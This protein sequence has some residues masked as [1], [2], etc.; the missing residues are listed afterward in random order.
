MA[1]IADLAAKITLTQ[2]REVLWRCYNIEQATGVRYTPMFIGAPGNGK[3]SIVEQ[4]TLELDAKLRE[5]GGAGAICVPF[6]LAQC[7][8]TDLKGVPVY[9]ELNGKKVC[10]YAPPRNIPLKG[11]PD[12]ADG[13]F[14]VLFLDELPQALPTIQNLASNIVDGKIGDYEIDFSRCFIVVA[15]NRKEDKAAV[16]DTPNNV[17]NRVDTLIVNITFSEWET[18]AMDRGLSPFVIGYLK[19]HTEFFNMIPPDN[20]GAYATPRVWE[21]VS[22]DIVTTGE[23]WGSSDATLPMLVG[24]VG[25]GPAHDFY[26]FY[27][28]TKDKYQLTDILKGKDLNVTEQDVIYRLIYEAVY[29]IN[30]NIQP[31]IQKAAYLQAPPTEKAGV[32]DGLMLKADIV[33]GIN[34]IYKWVDKDSIDPGFKVLLNKFQKR[35][36]SQPLRTVFFHNKSLAPAWVAYNNIL[37]KLQKATGS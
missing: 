8:P 5:N 18:W 19:A 30:T 1:K 6:R 4:F 21:K 7:D 24:L 20:G 3:S 36:I 34:N 11:L 9:L 27:T 37:T 32:L 13:K 31:L 2:A 25:Q 10:S 12:S 26:Q 29:W 16:Y 15:G 23:Q 17:R 14:A 22:C 28:T 33:D 35:D